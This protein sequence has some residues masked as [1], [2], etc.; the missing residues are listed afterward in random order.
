MRFIPEESI[1]KSIAY[2][3]EDESN[4]DQA[5]LTFTHSQPGITNYL[6]SEDFESLTEYEKELML[7]MCI[8]IYQALKSV[9]PELPQLS[10]DE[11][12]NAEEVNWGKLENVTAKKFKDRLDVFFH[13]TP[14]EDLL[15]F[16]EDVLIEEEEDITKEGREPIFVALKSV[17][18]V[19]QE[20]L[21]EK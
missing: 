17:I 19:F 6:L 7:Y 9:Y 11:I 1:D 21:M 15:A 13:E 2:L 3:E 4:Y 10:A 5:L 8:I 20:S 16:L 18:D 14:Q 12:E